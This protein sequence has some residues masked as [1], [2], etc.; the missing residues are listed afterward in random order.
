MVYNFCVVGK[1]EA[2][3]TWRVINISMEAPGDDEQ[4]IS[5]RFEDFWDARRWALRELQSRRDAI[6]KVMDKW[7]QLKE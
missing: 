5:P 4:Y 2:L 1:E 3:S 7:Y 6:G